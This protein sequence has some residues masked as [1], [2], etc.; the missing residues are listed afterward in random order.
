MFRKNNIFTID[1]NQHALQNCNP[2]SIFVIQNHWFSDPCGQWCAKL[3]STLIVPPH[4]PDW[5]H[6][7]VNLQRPLDGGSKLTK[8]RRRTGTITNSFCIRARFNQGGGGGTVTSNILLNSSFWFSTFF[9]FDP[10]GVGGSL[11]S[12][13]F[14]LS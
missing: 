11:P 6:R 2:Y 8:N 3:T 4:P 14:V 13:K 12:K 7:W 5:I 9:G 1:Q 10:G